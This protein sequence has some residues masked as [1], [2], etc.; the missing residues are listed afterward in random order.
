MRLQL[1]CS[2]VLLLCGSNLLAFEPDVVVDNTDPNGVLLSG[3][4]TVATTTTQKYGA[5]WIHDANAAA[6]KSA[7]FTPTLQ[8]PGYY[9]VYAWWIS[10]TAY[11]SS[12][13][14]DIVS[15]TG[16]STVN[17]N[18]KANGGKWN[19]LGVFKFDAGTTGSVTVRNSGAAAGYVIADA[20]RFSKLS[21]S[22]IANSSDTTGVTRVGTWTA[23]TN[24]SGY[25]GTSLS[26]GNTG[27]GTKSIT[28]APTLPANGDYEI[29]M[30][31]P[32]AAGQCASLPV[33]IVTASGTNSV[34]VDQSQNGGKW[35]FLGT[36]RFNAG[37]TGKV[38][39]NNANTVG[40][41][42][43]DAVRFMKV[44]LTETVMDDA[45]PSDVFITAPVNSPWTIG[46]TTTQ[47][48][49]PTWMHDGNTLR[50]SKS[51]SFEPN[52]SVRGNYD[53]YMWWVFSA[54][55]SSIVNVTVDGAAGPVGLTVN[56]RANGGQWV[57]L[58]KFDMGPHIQY[59][60][61]PLVAADRVYISNAGANGYVTVDAV[62]FVLDADSDDD[63]M[64]DNWE[65]QYFGDIFDLP[66]TDSDDDGASNHQEYVNGTDPMNAPPEITLTLPAT[67][68]LLP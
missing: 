66:G 9:Q 61:G 23:V 33:Q 3:T 48:F 49:G 18:Q 14:I 38:V 44:G 65:R 41:V 36:H 52:L 40:T 12:V 17:V 11:S 42:V 67:A 1:L 34:T 19:L 30:W 62:N 32:T 55:Y 60:G 22:V 10:N 56:E 24:T 45:D 53:V 13:P 25:G 31:W 51:V 2:F 29:S 68:V 4:W 64:P 54:S 6:V 37:T 47:K 59:P 58:G 57:H 63:G 20:I 50:G 5:D 28:F 35:V 27:K 46:T 15:T 16:T 43:A 39:I 7:R 21:P 26:D 8:S